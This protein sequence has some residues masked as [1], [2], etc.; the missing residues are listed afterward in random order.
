M[1][2]QYIYPQNMRTQA[3][4]WFWNLKDVIIL[5][6]ALTISVVSWA[7]LGFILP[8]ALTLGYAFLSIRMDEYSVLDF[9]IRAWRYLFPHSNISVG[10]SAKM[11]KRKQSTAELIGISNFSRNGLQTKSQGEI[12]YFLVQPTNIS[13]LSE[14]S[15]AIKI[16]HLMQLLSVQPDIEIICS[17]ARENFEYNKLSL[18]RRAE[19]ETN[20]KVQLLLRKDMKF[21]D[22][23]QLQMSTAR[24]FM[25]A[26]RVKNANDQSFATLNRL[27]KQIND[28]GFDCRRA[29]KDDIKRILSRYFG[30]MTEDAIDDV[31]GERM[32]KK[33]I[34]PD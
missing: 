20:L 10:R 33:W 30:H 11:A 15:V 5:A 27:E 25:F 9:I 6:I 31:D 7:K 34:I 16:Q 13:V 17:D 3:K 26:Y 19:K 12:V 32:I 21:L 1:Q 24:E 14:Q 28:Q 29:T 4:L 22:D 8:A 23:I 2:K 18:A